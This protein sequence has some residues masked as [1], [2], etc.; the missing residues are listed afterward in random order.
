MENR[1][2]V[3]A[4]QE[5]R[6]AVAEFA[7]LFGAGEYFRAHEVLEGPWLRAR[8]PEKDWLKGLIHAAVA[9]YHHSRGNAHGARVKRATALRYL[10]GVPDCWLGLELS[11]VRGRLEGM[12]LRVDG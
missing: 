2:T 4:E 11:T 8:Q 12:L 3:L 1:G 10:E 6:A 9:L 7:L 5:L